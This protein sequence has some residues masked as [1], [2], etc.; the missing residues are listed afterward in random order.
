MQGFDVSELVPHGFLVESTVKDDEGFII[1]IR[2]TA[3][4]GL[5]LS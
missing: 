2:G 1:A 5:L 3:S 4:V